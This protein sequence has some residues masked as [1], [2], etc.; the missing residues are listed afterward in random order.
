M[1]LPGTYQLIVSAEGK[2]CSGTVTKTATT[3]IDPIS[4]TLTKGNAGTMTRSDANTGIVTFTAG[5]TIEAADIVDVYWSGGIRYGMTATA[6]G[7]ATDSF[8]IDGGAGDDL[9]ATSE[10]AVVVT[11]QTLYDV[12][13]EPDN[14]Q[15]IGASSTQRTKV[16]F[17]DVATGLFGD[18]VLAQEVLA[19]G[20][21]GWASALGVANP[22][23]GTPILAVTA[24]NGS[25]TTDAS[26]E[27]VG[28]LA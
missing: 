28:L 14:L 5:H 26:F 11:Q 21:W 8:V 23:T 3:G 20:S 18:A 12:S 22:L 25:S 19:N 9:S 13:W 17:Y 4:A 16:I 10:I 15:L 6:N 1:S 7:T 24:S 2:T 27:L